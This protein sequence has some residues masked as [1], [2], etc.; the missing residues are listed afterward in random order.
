[1]ALDARRR[2]KKAEHRKAKQSAKKLA[3]KRRGESRAT[4]TLKTIGSASVLHC[5]ATDDVWTHGIGQV[6]VSRSL[7][8]DCVAASIFLL[9][10]F[11]L[12]VKD[13]T[14]DVGS[15]GHYDLNLYGRLRSAFT[16]TK[17]HPACARKLVEGAV[18]YAADLGLAAHADYGKAKVIFGDIDPGACEQEFAYGRDGKPFFVAGPYDTAARCKRIVDTLTKR[19]GPGGFHFLVPQANTE[20][21]PLEDRALTFDE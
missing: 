1:M 10:V 5:Y 13:A 3:M 14:F 2:Q 7:P 12:G 11:C 9:D 8:G 15:R 20:L 18:A 19:C 21:L 17:L 16:F 6:L 4:E